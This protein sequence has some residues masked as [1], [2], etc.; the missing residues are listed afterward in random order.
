MS[1]RIIWSKIFTLNDHS[2]TAHWWW[3][4]LTAVALIPLSLWFVISVITLVGADHTAVTQW[5][6]A[7][8]T[9]VL[10]LLFVVSVFHHAQLG[11]QVVIEDYIH[12]TTL[13]RA[14]G[15]GT[16]LFAALLALVAVWSV[17]RVAFGN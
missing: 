8:V 9:T 14:C 2:G 15:I 11:L 12:K 7:P 10:L 1:N 16:K 3:Q 6:R 17:L 4:R 5:V 13:V